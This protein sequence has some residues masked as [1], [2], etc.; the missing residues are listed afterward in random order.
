MKCNGSLLV[1]LSAILSA[2]NALI[3]NGNNP[4]ALVPDNSGD[5]NAG[6]NKT[7]SDNQ[8]TCEIQK[9]AEEMMEKMMKEKDVF[10]SIMEPLQSK[11]TDD[12]LCS[13][14]KYTN[15]CLHEKDKTP[16][17][18]PCTN[19]QYEQL[20]QQFT[21]KKLCNSKVAFSNV[22][23]KSFIDK[24]NEENTFNA[25]IQNYKVLSTCIDEDLKDIYNASIELFSDLRTSV[26]EITE[27]LWSKNMIEVLKTR[28]QAIAGILCELRNG[29]NSTL[30]SNSLSYE[31]FGIL[32][33]NYEGLINQAYK[34]F[35]D[36]YSYFPA[37]AIRLLEKD[38]LVER[39][40]AIH[41]SL[42][43]YRT[44]N[45][46]KKI[47]EKSKNEV[48]NNEDIM[49]SL[50]SYKHHAGGTRG[51]FMQYRGVGQLSKGGLSVDEKGGQQIASAVGNQSANMVA[52]APKDSSPTMAAPSTDT[53]TNNMAT[54]T[55]APATA[56]MAAPSTNTATA[57]MA[58]PSTNTA[59]ANMAAP[60]TDTVTTNMAT[61]TTVPATANTAASPDTNTDSS[62][63]PLYGTESSKTKDVVVLVRDLLKDTN[64]IK[65]EKNEPTSQID[66]EGIKKLIES[67]FFDLSDNTMLMRLIIKPQASIL[68]II[69][70]FI[71]MTPSPT[72]DAR[73]YCKKKLVNG[74]LI[75]N[76]DLKAETEE[77][78]M[79]NEFSSK[80]NLFY[81]R[82]KMEELREIEQDRKSLKNSKGNLSVLEVRNSQNGPDG[83]EVNGSGDAANGNNM[84]GGNNGSA[85]SLIVVVRDDLAEKTDDIIK[86]NVDL[87]S[88]KAD[89]E[90]AFRNFEY[91]SGSFSAN[92]SHA[93]VLLSSIALVLFIC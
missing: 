26:R 63:Y 91:Q 87:E 68:F 45:I 71:M 88:L 54:T 48:L 32:K 78:D 79:I 52:P 31:N 74:Q 57:N 90:Q 83:K 15:I 2:T 6:Q 3:R 65:F 10:S 55:T 39:L 85:S 16:L 19:P 4:Q 46:L 34:A 12:R 43:N 35:S 86:N 1:L 61:T 20:I 37:F 28:E 70:S 33:V 30:V 84:N 22:L 58:A 29:N 73:M 47:N 89:V 92:L 36:Y 66:D 81:E 41:E 21:Y 27:K 25:I 82:L 53:V 80:Y 9:M 72:R 42:T 23:L 24:K 64:I 60:S 51:S 7:S 59:T 8:D 11:L 14:M 62:T 5:P 38:G 50:S 17:T 13:K 49:H 93:L 75:E 44:R 67:S 76:N 56:N 77:E 69:Q 18:F 40:V